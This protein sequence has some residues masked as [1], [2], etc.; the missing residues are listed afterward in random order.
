MATS[1][2]PDD[3]YDHLP[4]E[5][6]WPGDIWCMLPSYGV[7]KTETTAGIVITPACDLQNNKSDTITYLP[8]VAV[9]SW[10]ATISVLSDVRAT[11]QQYLNQ[12]L[13]SAPPLSRFPS[14]NELGT[15]E[16]AVT[17]A[18]DKNNLRERVNAGLDAIRTI[19]SPA[20]HNA[21]LQKLRT[22]FGPKVFVE[23]CEKLV[24]NSLRSDCYFLPGR[25][26][27]AITDIPGDTF[28]GHSVAMFRYPLTAPLDVLE[29][30]GEAPEETW[31]QTLQ[32]YGALPSAKFFAHRPLRVARLKGHFLVDLLARYT[33]LYGRVGAS[34]F[35]ERIVTRLAKDIA[36]PKT[37][38]P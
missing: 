34:D 1:A 26:S 23:R 7:L 33:A 19:T 25:N 16:R 11:T 38:I 20:S 36:D 28:R 5:G 35:S 4:E 27:W 10:Y 8:V 32:A 17:D 21:D 2:T 9:E 31:P 3:Y 24:R 37:T 15:I 30:A 6:H 13:E 14:E 18:K 29:L 12:L 22:L